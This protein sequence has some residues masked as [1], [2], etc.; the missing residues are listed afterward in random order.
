[1]PTS[2]KSN[3]SNGIKPTNIFYIWYTELCRRTNKSPLSIVR[4]AKPK[5][6]TVLD[7]VTDRIKIDEWKPIL[8]ALRTDSSLHVI[9]VK[10]RIKPKFLFDIDT[11]EKIRSLK[12][13]FGCLW[14]D[15]IMN[16][17]AKS[18]S[19]SV[20]R[21]NVITCLELDGLPLFPKYLDVLIEGLKK[22][23]SVK[24]LSF[25]QSCIMDVGCQKLCM[26]IRF[27]PNI[28]VLNLTGCNLT[29]NSAEFIAKLIR[30]QQINRY[31]VSWHSS[32]RYADPENGVMAGL[33]RITLNNNHDIG[34]DGLR[35]ILDEL[36]DDLWIKAI[37][38]Q[39]CNITEKMA[40]RLLDVIDYSKSLEIADFRHNDLLSRHTIE[41]IF[42]ILK[43]KRC[44]GNEESEFQWC[45]ST[46][47]VNHS[48]LDSYSR[49][50]YTTST[51]QKS[52]SAPFKQTDVSKRFS[53][54]HV[55]PLRRTKTF[56]LLPKKQ[57][58]TDKTC[59]IVIRDNNTVNKPN[60]EIKQ[61]LSETCE[62]VPETKKGSLVDLK[63]KIEIKI[64]QS[65][66]TKKQKE[67]IFAPSNKL[68]QNLLEKLISNND[69][70]AEDNEENEQFASYYYDDG[71]N[72]AESRKCINRLTEDEFSS[73]NVSLI[74]YLQEIK[75]EHNGKV[76][77]RNVINKSTSNKQCSMEDNCSNQ[78]KILVKVAPVR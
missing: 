63:P 15:Y 72:L 65:Y 11:D 16:N 9:S 69:Y 26:S 54:P 22:N 66:Q 68:A 38:M 39:R 3:T 28:E 18:L 42:N 14:T 12:R 19:F 23:Q 67:F 75:N 77:K 29:S 1:M 70:Y 7:F 71:F 10:S 8:N 52:K 21:S 49:T 60:Q 64:P 46:T 35:V 30:H 27:M 78:K 61:K 50:T 6:D 17:F 58:C 44:I 59:R 36:D 62:F 41:K 5:N 74:N 48:V 43:Q 47:T 45:I 4:P 51:I 73:S 25:K 53:M 13:R 20:K 31:C 40:L 57:N 55:P 2:V 32:L 37:D 76:I 24:I 34:D 56:S 33:K